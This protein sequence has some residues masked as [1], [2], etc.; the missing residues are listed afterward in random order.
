[1]KKMKLFGLL[2]AL[3]V[4]LGFTAC[5]DDDDVIISIL[6][7]GIPTE[8]VTVGETAQ[9]SYSVNI[10]KNKLES[11][12]ISQKNDNGD[13][14]TKEK[15]DKF[16][17]NTS[18][19]GTFS[20]TPTEEEVGKQA[21]NLIVIDNKG[22]YGLRDF[23]IDVESAYGEIE[24]YEAVLM[25]SYDS[26]L[27]SFYSISNNKTYSVADA[28]A[29]SSVIDFAYYYGATNL[30]VIAAPSDSE[31]AT[32]YAGLTGLATWTTRNATK[33]KLESSLS[34][35]EFNGIENDALIA[36]QSDITVSKATKLNKGDIVAFETAAGKKGLFFVKDIKGTGGDSSITI[37][38]KVQK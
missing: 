22:N 10:D 29:N 30:A 24:N 6:I 25:G 9:I 36:S 16:T 12:E 26:K 31:A 11:I 1:M 27:G 15:I 23:T 5:S 2:M 28:K 18:Y 7:E 38:V 32:V 21:F 4:G 13:Y 8:A 19:N 3:I 20:Y 34:E 14:E 17:S 37:N 35:E 33:F